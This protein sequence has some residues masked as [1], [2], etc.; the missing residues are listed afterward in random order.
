MAISEKKRL[1]I[2]KMFNGR[3]SYCG[4]KLDYKLF[5]LDHVY[6]V[7]LGG[8]IKNN[9]VPSCYECNKFKGNS[10]LEDFR[11]KLSDGVV[12]EYHKNLLYKYYGIE[13]EKQPIGFY[14]E[15]FDREE[16]RNAT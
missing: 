11:K 16:F 15:Q 7:S 3:C 13:I 9:L 8:R 6:A 10:T 2:F 5:E 12:S 4:C 14:Y 1:L